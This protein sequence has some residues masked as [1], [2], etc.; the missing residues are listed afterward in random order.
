MRVI[1]FSLIEYFI[2]ALNCTFD[3]DDCGW[4]PD[5]DITSATWSKAKKS[6]HDYGPQTDHTGKNGNNFGIFND[7]VQLLFSVFKKNGYSK[8]S[9]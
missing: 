7:T 2:A 9:L 4:H 3:H 1:I 6:P 8:A 5:N